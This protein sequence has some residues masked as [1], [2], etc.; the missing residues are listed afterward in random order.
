MK[1]NKNGI[2][3]S[4]WDGDIGEY[5]DY[6]IDSVLELVGHWH[7]TFDPEDGLTFGDL[8]RILNK[9][10]PEG[11]PYLD[12]LLDTDLKPFLDESMKVPTRT[13]EQ[14]NLNRLEIYWHPEIDKT[15]D[16]ELGIYD[17]ADCFHGFGPVEDSSRQYYPDGIEEIAYGVSLTPICDLMHLP[18][19][20]NTDWRPYYDT[21]CFIDIDIMSKKR[22][23]R[24]AY[25]DALKAYMKSIKEDPEIQYPMKKIKRRFTLGWAI[26]SIFYD[27][28]FHGGPVERDYVSDKLFKSVEDVENGTVELTEFDFFNGCTED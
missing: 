25:S 23:D 18:L 28:G 1:L 11:D 22:S 7:E 26:R 27:L 20:F 24:Q 19:I 17:W 14:I 10:A 5:V 8:M 16:G 2:F 15:D 9:I 4:N 13:P 12:R 6:P 3:G 21:S